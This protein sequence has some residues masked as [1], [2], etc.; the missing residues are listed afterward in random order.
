MKICIILGTRPEIIKM[1]PIIRK[2]EKKKLDYFIIHTNQHY[3]NN[4]DKVFFEELN[5]PKPKFNLQI[6]SGNHGEQTG[7]MLIHIENVLINEKPDIILVQGDTNTVVAGALS[8]SKLGIKVGHVEAGLRR[9]DKGMPEEINRIVTDH[10]SDYLFCPTLIQKEILVKEGINREKIFVTGNTIA[11]S[12]FENEKI[13]EEKSSI[14]KRLDLQASKKYFVV[15]AHR[16]S[17]VDNRD[18]LKKIFEILKIIKIRYNTEIIYPIHP[19][20]F[21]NIK[22]FDIKIPEE[23]RLIEPLGYLDF[24]KLMSSADLI[25]TDSGG[26]QEEAC[27]LGIPCL[28]LRDNTERPETINAGSNIL[29]GLD[30]NKI[31]AAIESYNEKPKWNN[32]FGDGRSSERI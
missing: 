31:L 26:I 17:N 27:I 6:G 13:A 22:S 3:S 11:D 18:N 9:Y 4:M 29:V 24:L 12:I 25:L 23:I 16:P 10:I 20:T 5:L 14:L 2:L 15:T 28:T 30:I 8:A 19:R 21:N 7:K 1:A 32:P